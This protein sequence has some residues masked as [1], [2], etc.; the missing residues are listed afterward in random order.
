MSGAGGRSGRVRLRS[1][2]RPEPSRTRTVAVRASG[3]LTGPVCGRAS[4]QAG[5]A[6]G[7]GGRG[8]EGGVAGGEGLVLEAEE[9]AGP[10]GDLAGHRHRRLALER[11]VGAGGA[12]EE[13]GA[14][15]E[16][17]RGGGIDRALGQGEGEV[18]ALGGEVLDE[19]GRGRERRGLGVGVDGEAP[20]AGGGTGADREGQRPA[21][22]TLVGEGIAA[23]LD[24]VGAGDDGGERQALD[25]AGAVVAGEDGGEDGLARP[26][27]AALGRHE[28]VD[29]RRGGAAGD[30]A[31]GEVEAGLGEA[32]EGEVLAGL[33]GDEAGLGA[34][35]AAQEAGVEAGVARRRR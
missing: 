14:G 13:V 5:G 35:P 2:G 32:E 19:E 30:A 6:V 10:A 27:G 18:D 22:G 21:A 17:G 3:R 34:A 1:T 26:V 7:V 23:V 16:R 20:A 31:V 15:L 12:P 8:G 29:R 25:G 24:P 9:E 11:E 4:G 28:D 33:G